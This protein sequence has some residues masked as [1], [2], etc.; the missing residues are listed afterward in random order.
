MVKVNSRNISAISD[1]QMDKVNS[2]NTSAM[3]DREMD[4]GKSKP[5]KNFREM[6]QL[7]LIGII[8]YPNTKTSNLSF[9]R[10]FEVNLM[11]NK[12]NLQEI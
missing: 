11:K 1:L 7:Q 9:K 12:K 6:D 10:Q 2:R 3:L 5:K 4:F 8:F